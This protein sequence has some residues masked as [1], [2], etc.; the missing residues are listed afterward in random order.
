VGSWVDDFNYH[1]AMALRACG[2]GI[3]AVAWASV[4]GSEAQ[5]ATDI[6]SYAQ[7]AAA[8]VSVC[9][10]Q[11]LT[12]LPPSV[13]AVDLLRPLE[14]DILA[15]ARARAGGDAERLRLLTARITA[16]AAVR[17]RRGS[18]I[19]RDRRAWL[20]VLARLAAGD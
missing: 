12:A 17:I 4:L 9:I 14:K 11:L 8:L 7:V 19:P 20:R 13:T 10:V 6:R 2:I 5:Q 18:N 16:L 3:A 15:A 1:L